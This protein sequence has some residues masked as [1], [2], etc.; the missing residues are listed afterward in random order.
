MLRRDRVQLG[1]LFDRLGYEGFG[2]A[3]LVL[4]LPTIIPTPGPVGMTFGTVIALV[5]L[6]VMFGA[7][8]V[9]LPAF[10]RR[11]TVPG[12][13][14]RRG[15]AVALPYLARAERWLCEHRLAL[16][17]RG[18]ARALLGL[19][20]FVLA[21]A[22]AL[23]IPFGNTAPALALLVFAFG[24]MARDGAA[25]AAA[26]VLTVLAVAWTAFLFLAGASLF[27]WATA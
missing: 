21:V 20:I 6:Q 26:L 9:W 2:L 10:L 7:R 24:F 25:I 13:A 14:L 4:T 22:I 27:G 17:T 16:L 8:G 18:P 5:A 1:E 19:P 15:I 11:R 12:A 3:L 23:P